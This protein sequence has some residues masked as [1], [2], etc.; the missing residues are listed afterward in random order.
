M[1]DD[2]DSPGSRHKQLGA[3]SIAMTKREGTPVHLEE[4]GTTM[5]ST[6]EEYQATLF[7]QTFATAL[8]Y[9]AS[10]S[11]LR[12]GLTPE[13]PLVRLSTISSLE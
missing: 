6:S 9:G 7:K 11:S 3:F 2:P 1:I 10:S 5:S 8:M 4:F 12:S 13:V